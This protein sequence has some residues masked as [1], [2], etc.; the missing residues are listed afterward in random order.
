[1]NGDID[2]LPVPRRLPVQ[3]RRRDRHGRVLAADPQFV[4]ILAELAKDDV[5]QRLGLSDLQR[6]KLDALIDQREEEVEQLVLKIMDLSAADQEKQ[7]APFRQES[8]KQGL[9]LLDDKQRA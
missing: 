5:A 3:E 8:E 4:G 1:M 6:S 9:A 2:E 7:L